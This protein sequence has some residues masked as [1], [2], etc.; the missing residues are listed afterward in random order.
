MQKRR[1]HRLVRLKSDLSRFS[2]E[3]EKNEIGFRGRHGLAVIVAQAR[4]PVRAVS[5]QTGFLLF[6]LFFYAEEGLQRKIADRLR[7]LA[8][9]LRDD[10]AFFIHRVR[11]R[12]EIISVQHFKAEYAGKKRDQL[13]KKAVFDLQKRGCHKSDASC[14]HQK[15]GALLAFL[16]FF[17]C[18]LHMRS[19]LPRYGLQSVSMTHK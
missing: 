19:F 2:V 14:C 12:G 1:Y 5:L 17:R 6:C 3:F 15:C 16:I 10:E 11:I 9:A 4:R 13:I 18:V 8:R 7:A